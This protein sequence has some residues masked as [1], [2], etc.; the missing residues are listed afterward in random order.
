MKG[1]AL[2]F[3]IVVEPG[4]REGVS[5]VTGNLRYVQKI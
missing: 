3:V 4:S 2:F 1:N 5:V